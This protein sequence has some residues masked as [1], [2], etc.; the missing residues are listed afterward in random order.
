M[1]KKIEHKKTF[2]VT[3][4]DIKDAH[5]RSYTGHCSPCLANFTHLVHLEEEGEEH[6]LLRSTGLLT[7][8]GDR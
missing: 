4:V 6:W 5:W 3:N 8:V 7:A 1:Y 2:E